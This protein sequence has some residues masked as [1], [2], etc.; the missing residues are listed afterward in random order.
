M[1]DN[2]TLTQ[3]LTGI[4][5]KYSCGGVGC[6]GCVRKG[7]PSCSLPNFLSDILIAIRT[8]VEGLRKTDK[9]FAGSSVYRVYN[10][11]IDDVLSKLK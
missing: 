11:A 7:K 1:E 8:D 9:D 6:D 4:F 2:L 10:D 3:R 5:Q